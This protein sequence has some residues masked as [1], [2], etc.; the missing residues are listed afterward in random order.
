[1]VASGRSN[2]EIAQTMQLAIHT[3]KKHLQNIYIK[4]YVKNRTAAARLMSS[5]RTVLAAAA[6]KYAELL[7]GSDV[8]FAPNNGRRRESVRASTAHGSKGA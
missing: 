6:E 5:S 4:L 8:S 1:M 2:A 3:V 7:P